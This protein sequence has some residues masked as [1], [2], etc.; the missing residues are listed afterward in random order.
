M[1]QNR[2]PAGLAVLGWDRMQGASLV[3]LFLKAC[4]VLA[5]SLVALRLMAL[6]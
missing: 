2:L 3:V 4:G 6:G 1:M 5:T